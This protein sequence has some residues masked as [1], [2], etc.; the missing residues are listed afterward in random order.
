LSWSY[1]NVSPTGGPVDT[2]NL[3]VAK[4]I[5]AS[6][7][8]GVAS[9]CRRRQPVFKASHVGSVFRLDDRDLSLTP[10]WAALETGIA[11]LA[12][13]RWQGNVYE[14]RSGAAA[15]AGPN[16]PVHTE[17]D[18]S[19]GAGFVTWRFVHPGYGFVRITACS[20]TPTHV[21]G[22]VI[23][24]AGDRRQRR[25]LPLVGAG[26]GQRQRLSD[27]DRLGGAQAVAVPQGSRSGPRSTIC[28]RISP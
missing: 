20:P 10:E 9:R 6:A 15:S 2:Q 18:V 3:D 1:A 24:V 27:R 11:A 21:T 5:Q 8:T 14:N 23:D 12:L 28:R 17:G 26:L 7:A 4:T 16:A 19:A 22:D 25:H 13:R